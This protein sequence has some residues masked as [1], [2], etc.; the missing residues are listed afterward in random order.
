MEIHKYFTKFAFTQSQ[1][2]SSKY[3]AN[4]TRS[5]NLNHIR[6]N[7]SSLHNASRLVNV[8]QFNNGAAILSANTTSTKLFT[9]VECLSLQEKFTNTL[10]QTA[11]IYSVAFSLATTGVDFVLLRTV[12]SIGGTI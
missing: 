3:Y 12:I 4:L 1:C 10:I 7:K 2:F 6:F 9:A 11:T 8:K 5:P